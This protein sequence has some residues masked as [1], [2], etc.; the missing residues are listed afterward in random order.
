MV[1]RIKKSTRPVERSLSECQIVAEDEQCLEIKLG[2]DTQDIG[3]IDVLQL[4]KQP[5][6]NILW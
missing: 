4:E 2:E 5:L 3:V 6:L 1:S